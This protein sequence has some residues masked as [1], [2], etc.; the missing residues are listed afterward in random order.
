MALCD[1]F[2]VLF[3]APGLVY[4]FTFGNHYK[5]LAPI[6][7]CYAYNA[8]NEVSDTAVHETNGKKNINAPSNADSNRKE[9]KLANFPSNQAGFWWGKARANTK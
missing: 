6:V 8:F 9:C 5:P 2:T 3:P 4:M 7:A 1:M